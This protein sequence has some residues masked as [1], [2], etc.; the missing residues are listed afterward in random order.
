MRYVCRCEGALG[1]WNFQL[2]QRLV[3]AVDIKLESYAT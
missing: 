3:W 2:Q 1:A